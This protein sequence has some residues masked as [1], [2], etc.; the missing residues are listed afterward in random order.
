M[1]CGDARKAFWRDV[2]TLCSRIGDS[3]SDFIFEKNR[4]VAGNFP[5][6]VSE[7]YEGEERQVIARI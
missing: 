2:A 1:G 5:G 7:R 4:R 3:E 6:F